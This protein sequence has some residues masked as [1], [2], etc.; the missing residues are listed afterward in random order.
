[1]ERRFA[2]SLIG[3]AVLSAVVG[4]AST[5]QTTGNDPQGLLAGTG[6]QLQTLGASGAL[7]EPQPTLEFARPDK[8]SGSGSCNR[9]N[10]SVTVT[11]KSITFGPLASTR[12][13]CADALNQ[14]ESLYFKALAQA[15]WFTIGGTTLT[16]YTKAMDEPLV[17]S[18][19]NPQ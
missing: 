6:W 15:Q 2:R 11:G 8:V 3:V 10:G 7:A 19:T 17:F 18:H 12:M 1:M 13:A 16:I 9:F 14:Q 4:C 5:R